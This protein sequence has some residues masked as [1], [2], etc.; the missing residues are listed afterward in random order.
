[1]NTDFINSLKLAW[2]VMAAIFLV[3]LVIYFFVHIFL[4]ITGRKKKT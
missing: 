4:K 2:M 1:M 3:I